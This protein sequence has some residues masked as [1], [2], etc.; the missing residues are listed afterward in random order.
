[1]SLLEEEM[2]EASANIGAQES[3]RVCSAS[4]VCVNDEIVEKMV[5]ASPFYRH[6][7]GQSTCTRGLEVVVF[8]LNGGGAVVG[9]C[10]KYTVE[11]WRVWRQAWRS[12]WEAP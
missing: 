9:C 1:M 4:H 11:H 7:E 8:S 3:G 2:I 6:K 12:S 10:W 5:P